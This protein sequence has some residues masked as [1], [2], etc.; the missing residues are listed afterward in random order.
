[1]GSLSE[2]QVLNIREDLEEV[3]QRIREI[4]AK[5][6]AEDYNHISLFLRSET[7]D[8]VFS[9]TNDIFILN[10][11]AELFSLS[12]TGDDSLMS[13]K[14]RNGEWEKLH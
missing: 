6:G 10:M 11:L 7:N 4:L 9:I 3:D 2:E 8:Y 12:D 14:E 13:I 5:H 1:M